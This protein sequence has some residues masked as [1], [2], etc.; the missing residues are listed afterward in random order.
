MKNLIVLSPLLLLLLFLSPLPSASLPIPSYSKFPSIQAEKLIRELNLFPKESIN[1]VD[2][3][4]SSLLLTKNKIVE[5]R[6]KFP[7]LADSS[8]SVED[9]GHHAGYY[10]IEHSHAAK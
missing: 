10:Q 9:L 7:N 4:H 6:F 3:N 2:R 5:K 1:I 8:V